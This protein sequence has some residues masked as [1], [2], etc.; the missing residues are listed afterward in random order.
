MWPVPGQMVASICRPPFVSCQTGWALAHV[1][2]FSQ[3][4]C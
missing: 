4:D 1:G 3:R 2:L